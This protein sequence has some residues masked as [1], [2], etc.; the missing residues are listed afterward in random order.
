[1]HVHVVS[2]NGEAKSWLYPELELAENYRCSRPQLKAIESLIEED[3]NE[4]VNAWEQQ[5][6]S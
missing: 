5:F 1:M 4:L 3:Y 2:G 6:G